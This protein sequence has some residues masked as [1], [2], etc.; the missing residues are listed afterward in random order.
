LYVRRLAQLQ[1]TALAGTTGARD[2]FFSPDGQWLGFF[3]DGKLK[4]ISVAGGAAVTLADAPSDRGG[5]WGDDGSI[6]FMPNA[7]PAGPL[8]RISSAGGGKPEAVTTLA[9]GEVTHRWPQVLPGA[10]AIL[11]TAH[12]APNTLDNAN[13]VV[14]TLPAGAP[15]IV[16]RG[17][18]HAQFLT[19]GHLVFIHNGTLFAAPFDLDR[20]E[21]SGQPVPA[22]EGVASNNATGGA[23][24]A[25]APT[26]ALVYLAGE[27][28]SGGQPI[29]WMR[30]DGTSSSLRSTPADWSNP[31]FAPDGQRLAI[32][33][34]DP[35][36]PTDIWVYEPAR[37]TLTWLTFDPRGEQRP[38]W[39]PDGRRIVYAADTGS[40]LN[41]HW[42]RA[43]G[44]TGAAQRLTESPNSQFAGS[45]H[46]GGKYLSFFEN[47]PQ[48]A[49]DLMILP[50]EGD[51]A[52]GWKIGKPT[53]FLS[54]PF[55]ESE[56]MFSPDG[57]WM[58]YQSNETG[59][60]EVFVR[61]FPGLGGRWQISTGGGLLPTWSQTRRELLYW[62]PPGDSR[63]M[64]ASYSTEGDS[65][66]A[67]KPRLW[68]ERAILP[69]P[70]QRN[71]D[72]HPDG[73][74]L[75]AAVS[76]DTQGEARP[77]KVVFVLN[78][79]DELRRIAPTGTR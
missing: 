9:E 43:D 6:V 42:V 16:H 47:N 63:I 12:S 2:P 46:P 58:A 28:L 25:I 30:R 54:T 10:R 73:E 78:F 26:G 32:D 55:A 19:S 23:Q 35:S 20:L 34:G 60:T 70:G 72:L 40:N 50:V 3:A 51:E 67:D 61:P 62:T 14:Q 68:S 18:Y 37:D 48:T 75:A 74:R 38:V 21:L 79:F 69:R 8:M 56:P 65:F 29:L 22:I 52:S 44:S 57:K 4:K 5:A 31:R 15:K 33:I 49:S 59:T 7:G 1:A 24:F 41:L 77:D 36:G 76:T 39:T 45:W 64:V 13:I 27:S 11:Y 71:F 17:G 66:K 53:V